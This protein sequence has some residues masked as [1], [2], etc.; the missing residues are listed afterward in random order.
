MART[1]PTHKNLILTIVALAQFMVVLD[2]SIV[3]VAL[4]AIYR[5]LHFT[6]TSNL[7]WIVTAYTLTFGGFLLLGGRAADLFGRK[8]VFIAGVTVFSIASL[9]TALSVNSGMIEITRGFQGLAA[10]FMSPAALSILITTFKEGHERNVALSIWGGIAAGGAGVGVLIGGILTQYLS[11]RWNFF[12]NV[13]VGIM[14]VAAA[15]YYI[16]ESDAGLTHRHLDLKG[17]LFVTLGLISLVF[18]FTKAPTY[19]WTGHKTLEIFATSLI[20]LIAFVINEL[21][22]KH[23]LIPFSIFKIGNIA[24]ADLTQLPVTACLY[25][26]FFFVSLYI[27]QVLH[28]SPVRTGLGFIPVT[29]V[30]GFMASQMSKVVRKYGYKRPLM[31]API[32]MGAGLFW[33]SRIKVH[34]SYLT[35]VLPGL[36]IIALGMGTIFVSITIAATSGVPRDK[37]GL[38][39][40]LLNTAQQVGG[41]LGLA[42]LSGVSASKVASYLSS[43][44][45]QVNKAAYAQVNGSKYAF[46]TGVAFAIVALLLATFLIKE[47]RSKKLEIDP[48]AA[49]AL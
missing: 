10:A 44:A 36:I 9:M 26:M 5:S 47:D 21:K 13:P 46:L 49:A 22:V 1:K 38:S 19:G 3:N 30:I 41:A 27:Q 16:D 4:P 42:I 39:S 32:F 34:D 14:V 29:I 23:P 33:L 15:L 40:G 2:V 25:S 8:K 37:A 48:A 24:A 6:S 17:A 20:L 31:I 18:G 11:W 12:I 28:Y 7:Q 43:H 35:G 45:H